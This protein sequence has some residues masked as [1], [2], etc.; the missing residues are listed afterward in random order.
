MGLPQSLGQVRADVGQIEQVLMNLAVNAQDAMPNGGVLSIGLADVTIADDAPQ[1]PHAV[2]PGH[3]VT[4]TVSDTGCGMDK[5]TMERLFEPFFTTKEPGKGT[6]L[7]LST[8][9]GIVRQHGGHIQACSQPGVGTTFRICLPRVSETAIRTEPTAAPVPRARGGKGKET[10][11][12]VEDNSLV[13]EVI[14]RMLVRQGYRAV[15]AETP[16]RAIETVEAER[17]RI[18]LLLTDII[19]PEMNGRELYRQLRALHPGLRVICM[20]GYDSDAVAH[21]GMLE[22]GIPLLHKPFEAS[23]LGET[24]RKA[25]A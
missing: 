24:V 16:S 7:G 15:P 17:D 4:L 5:T 13:R 22:D 12:V 1:A 14:C 10:I 23:L 20:S 21:R 18:D 19:M 9:Y 6:G 3:Y 8:A 25:L 11:L 2:P